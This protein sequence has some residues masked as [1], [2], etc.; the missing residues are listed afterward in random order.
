MKFLLN[1]ELMSKEEK[2]GLFKGIS[3]NYGRM[4]LCL[5]GGVMF[6]YYY[7]GVVKVLLE[8]DKL[9]DIIM[10][11]LGGV[12]VVVLVVIRMNEELK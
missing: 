7:F 9:L 11:M 12:L 3:V 2:R 1:M 8:E 10:G 5:S 6:V 4:V